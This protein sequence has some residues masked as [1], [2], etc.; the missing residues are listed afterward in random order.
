MGTTPM[1]PLRKSVKIKCG[2]CSSWQHVLSDLKKSGSGRVLEWGLV[3]KI[4]FD[5][6]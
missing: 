4:P 5:H 1:G 2:H 6:G 3:E